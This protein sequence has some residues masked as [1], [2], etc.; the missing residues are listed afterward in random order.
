MQYEVNVG[1]ILDAD[2]T[3]DAVRQMV[4][5]LDDYRY[6]ALYRLETIPVGTDETE[7]FYID[8][9]LMEWR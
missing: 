9:A 1:M 2:S 5:W 7:T 4:A 6:E 8:A 3:L